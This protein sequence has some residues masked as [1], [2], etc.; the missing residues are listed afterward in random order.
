MFLVARNSTALHEVAEIARK[1]SPHVM[2]QAID[3]VA[4]GAVIDIANNLRQQFE[5]LDVL[6]H[7]SGA[8]SMEDLQT[9]SVDELDSCIASTCA[10]HIC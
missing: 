9:A 7:C 8:C 1:S 5:G 6:I 10:R 3:L 4:D 2:V